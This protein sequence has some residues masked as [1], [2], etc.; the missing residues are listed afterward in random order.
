MRWELS[1]MR[2]AIKPLACHTSSPEIDETITISPPD[3]FWRSIKVIDYI[4]LK[5][6]LPLK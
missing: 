3:G 2:L 5:L 6:T 4:I 1:D